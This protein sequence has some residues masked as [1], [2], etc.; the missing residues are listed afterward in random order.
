MSIN[1]NSL[2]TVV[3]MLLYIPA[4]LSANDALD[5]D[6]LEAIKGSSGEILGAEV[7]QIK[8]VD[9]MIIIDIDIP[10]EKLEDYKTVM[11][12]EKESRKPV[13]LAKEAELLSNDGEA[14]GVR[15]Q[16]KRLPGFEFRL[17]LHD[18]SE[19]TM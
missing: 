1:K 5:T 16:I 6:W 15:V 9:D 10:A 13:K 17:R 19:D 12:I 3:F 7:I 8:Q 11:V 2:R 18:G 14:Y 4:I